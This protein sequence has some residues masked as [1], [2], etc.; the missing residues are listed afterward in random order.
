MADS[1]TSSLN[2][3]AWLDEPSIHFRWMVQKSP[4]F[5]PTPPVLQQMWVMTMMKDGKPADQL[6]E[7]R[8]VPT[9]VDNG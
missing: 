2:Y 8:D 4:G 5:S 9:V 6:T 7:W 1:T 3:E